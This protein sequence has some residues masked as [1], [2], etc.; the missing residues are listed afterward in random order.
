MSSKKHTIAL[1]TAVIT[2]SL[3]SSALFYA[4]DMAVFSHK[5]HLETYGAEC[6]N[7]H[8]MDADDPGL[9]EESC[10]ACHDTALPPSRLKVQAKRTDIKFSHKRHNNVAECLDCHTATVKDRQRK[11]R[12]IQSFEKCQSCH[13][14][15]GISVPKGHC[16]GCHETTDRRTQPGSHKRAW[17]TRHGR[18]AEWRAMD[19]HES[20][21]L[22]HSKSQCITC[23]HTMKPKDH[24]ALWRIR[25]HGLGASWD[26]SRCK[27]CHETG[28]CI[29]CHRNTA[30]MSHRGAWKKVHGLAAGAKGADRCRVCHSSS[31]RSAPPCVDCHRRNR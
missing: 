4:G 12:V 8:H 26:R 27:T 15:N 19:P 23:H 9:K 31:F 21:T 11:G 20:C 13:A 10:K 5:E 18:E 1:A 22:C 14:E 30:P 24:T 3:T 2:A 29:N 28:T 6:A 7:C 17:L 25:T 16:R